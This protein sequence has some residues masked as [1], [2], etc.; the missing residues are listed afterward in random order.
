MGTWCGVVCQY[1]PY[2]A[3]SPL[4]GME[5]EW[6]V[7]DEGQAGGKPPV[8]KDLAGTQVSRS[9]QAA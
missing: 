4:P 9:S 6:E 5:D 3:A 8:P 2:D 1:Y 7:G